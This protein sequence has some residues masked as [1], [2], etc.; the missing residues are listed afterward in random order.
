MRHIIF[1]Y[2][3][4]LFLFGCNNNDAPI[5]PVPV[6][7]TPTEPKE[8]GTPF[9]DVPSVKDMVFYEVNMRAF[10]SAGD[11]KGVQARLDSIKALSVNVLWLMPIHPVGQLKSV[12]QLGSPYS[13]RDYQAVN[14]EFGTIEDLQNLVKEAHNR[15]MAVVIDWVANHTAWDNDW[16]TKNPNWYTK[17]AAGNITIPSG[18]NW[19]DV[20]DLNFDNAEMR[21]EMINS[22]KYWIYKANIDGFRCDA[23]DFVPFDFWKQANDSLQ[24]LTTRKIIMLAEGSRVDH[25]TAG[26]QLNYAWDFFGKAKNVYK[27]NQSATGFLSLQQSEYNNLP[28]NAQKL[29]FTT[30]HDESAWDDTPVKLFGNAKGAMGAFIIS[31]FMGGV[32]LIY[33][34]Q[35]VGR[36]DKTPFF[37]K[38][39]IDWTANA[40]YFNE[41]KNVMAFRQSSP[42]LRDGTL[43]TFNDNDVMVFKKKLNGAEVLVMVNT[44]NATINYNLPTALNNTNWKNALTNATLPL[45]NSVSFQPFQYFILKQ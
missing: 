35:E 31:T 15:K 42:V 32:P 7:T 5:A 11:F 30:N 13:V 6:V 9:A 25:F 14:P 29:R 40:D 26:F 10:S 43:E 1:T 3:L 17:D 34:G 27:N 23:A 33:A 12:G 22:M 8:F 36:V 41:F 44:R 18:T 20:A 21:K 24:K 39:P 19:Q 38:S 45:S 28:T 16:L 4:A 2:F 37:S